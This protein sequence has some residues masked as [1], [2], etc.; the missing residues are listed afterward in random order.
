MEIALTGQLETTSAQSQ[1][2]QSSEITWDFPFS[3][4]N[5]FGQSASQVPQ[6]MQ[7]SSFTLAFGIDFLLQ[8]ISTIR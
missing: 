2:P 5:T 8:L 3:I 6:P 1:S 4:L 7:I